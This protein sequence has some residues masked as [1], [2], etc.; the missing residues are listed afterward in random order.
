MKLRANEKRQQR[1]W[2]RDNE[3][4]LSPFHNTSRAFSV[5]ASERGVFVSIEMY[6]VI[7]WT[8]ERDQNDSYKGCHAS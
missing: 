2:I 5:F 4:H 1:N 8:V 3:C 7:Q 6:G